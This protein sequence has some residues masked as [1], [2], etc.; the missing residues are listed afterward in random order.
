VSYDMATDELA[1]SFRRG[2]RRRCRGEMARRIFVIADRPAG[3]ESM[4]QAL[5]DKGFTVL[6]GSPGPGCAMTLRALHPDMVIVDL[7]EMGY[8]GDTAWRA[9]RVLDSIFPAE[10]SVIALSGLPREEAM[11]RTSRVGAL[12][13]FSKPLDVDHILTFVC[14]HLRLGKGVTSRFAVQPIA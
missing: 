11:I 8:D 5:R 9:R 12:M 7:G 1:F 13:A 2:R 3:L 10:P 6:L 14:E 4:L